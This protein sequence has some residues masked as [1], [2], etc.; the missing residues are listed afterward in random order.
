MSVTVV[1]YDPTWAT[2]FARESQNIATALGSTLI[3]IHHIGSTAIP[4]IFAKPVVD[5]LGIATD[6]A[7]IEAK[8]GELKNLSCFAKGEFGIPGRRYFRKD[9]SSGIRLFQLHVFAPGAAAAEAHQ[10]FRD[11][12]RAH[13]EHAHA[14]S[15]LKR[16]LATQHA[17]DA[18]AYIAGKDTFVKHTLRQA[19]EW[20]HAS[21][22]GF[23][24]G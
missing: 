15:E 7:A 2:T 22:T 4:G 13:H 6:L 10:A 8:T 21:S 14:Y 19:L 24:G 16:R 12:M 17:H 11:Y 23:P 9:D 1:P 20:C 3:A 18:H 5:M